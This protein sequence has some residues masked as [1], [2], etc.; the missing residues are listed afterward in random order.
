ML[1]LHRPGGRQS[2]RS[3]L[4]SALRAEPGPQE[5]GAENAR[6]YRRLQRGKGEVPSPKLAP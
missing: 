2:T 5:W 1:P 4:G 6:L 3:L